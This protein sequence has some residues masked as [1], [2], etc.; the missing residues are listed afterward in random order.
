MNLQIKLP[1]E[2]LGVYLGRLEQ[3]KSYVFVEDVR[4]SADKVLC[5]I[6]EELGF[7][8]IVDAWRSVVNAEK[9]KDHGRQRTGNYCPNCG[10]KME[11]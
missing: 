4:Y 6:L 5:D 2:E 11:E 3:T 7:G 1:P 9:Q 8:E 10:A